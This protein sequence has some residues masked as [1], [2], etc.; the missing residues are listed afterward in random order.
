MM[1]NRIDSYSA[2]IIWVF[3]GMSI[4]AL[5]LLVAFNNFFFLPLSLYGL[6][7][8]YLAM[9]C[10]SK[11]F[12]IDSSVVIQQTTLISTEVDFLENYVLAPDLICIISKEK[13]Y[14]VLLKSN[15]SQKPFLHSLLNMGQRTPSVFVVK[16]FLGIPDD[17]LIKNILPL[18]SLFKS[19][20]WPKSS[21]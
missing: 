21:K 7:I 12:L 18:P 2:K 4:L 17:K 8:T 19:L 10:K 3:T 20:H 14:Y 1:K 11:V 15:L 16:Q 6:Y 13:T 9:K 5:F